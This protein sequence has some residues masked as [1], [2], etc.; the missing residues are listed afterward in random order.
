MQSIQYLFLFLHVWEW[1]SKLLFAFVLVLCYLLLPL[2][3][4]VRMHL[5]PGEEE[6]EAVC[7]EVRFS[8]Q[9]T[10][11]F[12]TTYMNQFFIILNAQN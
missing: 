11:L 3:Q 6:A 1:E 10:S 2:M 5:L 8:K 12:M 9:A 4:I 7:H